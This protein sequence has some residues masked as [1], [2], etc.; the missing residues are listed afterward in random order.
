MASTLTKPLHGK[1]RQCVITRRAC[2]SSSHRYWLPEKSLE[3]NFSLFGN[4]SIAPGHGHNYELI[5]SMGGELDSD[6]MVLNLSDVKH[7]IKNKVTGQLDFRFLMM[8]GRNSTFI[9][10]MEFFQLLKP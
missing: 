5:V 9:K 7:S 10:E 1:G 8:Y 2:F 4:C 6:G 3:E